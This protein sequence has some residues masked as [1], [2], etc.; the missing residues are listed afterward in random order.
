MRSFS[1]GALSLMCIFSLMLF[2]AGAPSS[3]LAAKANKAKAKEAKSGYAVPGSMEQKI[4]KP[5]ASFDVNKMGDMSDF[6]PAHW[7]PPTGDTIKIA[8]VSPFSGPGAI[9]GRSILRR[10]SSPPMTST[11]AAGLLVDGKKKMIEVIKAD[12]MSKP[13]QCKK[14]ASGWSCRR[15]SRS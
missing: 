4:P 9:N 6:D 11:S 2:L 13:D 5:N 1:R 8:Y 3:V 12:H 14:V 15:R 10:S 7:V